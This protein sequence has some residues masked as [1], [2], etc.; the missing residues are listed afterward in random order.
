MKDIDDN[1][2]FNVNWEEWAQETEPTATSTE[3]WSITADNIGQE[4]SVKAEAISNGLQFKVFPTVLEVE[5][6][7][8]ELPEKFIILAGGSFTLTLNGTVHTEDDAGLY[9]VQLNEIWD[10]VKPGKPLV[11][12]A[13]AFMVLELKA[14]GQ[15]T[16]P[17]LV[18]QQEADRI[19]GVPQN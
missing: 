6:D 11:G 3:T 7:G 8:K 18:S 13:D 14:G 5:P 16:T 15:T 2:F 17:Y 12:R 19:R 9:V 4:L 1:A 10:G